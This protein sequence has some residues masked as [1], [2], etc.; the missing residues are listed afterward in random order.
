MQNNI[1]KLPEI[2]LRWLTGVQILS[3]PP[4]FRTS[5]WTLN[6]GTAM[7][8]LAIVEGLGHYF[9]YFKGPGREAVET[10]FWSFDGKL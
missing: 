10:C 6:V 3:W 5:A 2:T 7:A 9:T 8:F 1:L 4:S